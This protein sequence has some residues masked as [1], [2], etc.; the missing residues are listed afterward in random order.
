MFAWLGWILLC[1]VLYYEW[2][3]AE[4]AIIRAFKALAADLTRI[5]NP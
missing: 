1:V 3:C 5:L 4:S 2:A